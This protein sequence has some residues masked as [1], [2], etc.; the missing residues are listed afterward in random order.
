[1]HYEKNTTSY[2]FWI[3]HL[4][5]LFDPLWV[6]YY[7]RRLMNIPCSFFFSITLLYRFLSLSS[8]AVSLAGW[9]FSIYL[10]ALCHQCHPF[11]VLLSPLFFPLIPP[12]NPGLRRALWGQ[13]KSTGS[14]QT[15]IADFYS[16]SHFFLI[17]LFFF[18]QSQTLDQCLD[19]AW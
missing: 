3:C 16:M 18:D 4:I 8:F 17:F 12:L 13:E 10:T 14:L 7:K 2:L 19:L 5:I 6:L 9:R 11:L 15:G 1:M